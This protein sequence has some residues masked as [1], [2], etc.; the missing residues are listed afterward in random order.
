M[1]GLSLLQSLQCTTLNQ[2]SVKCCYNWES[3]FHQVLLWLRISLASGVSMT[4]NQ[5][6]IRCCHDSESAFHQVFPQLRI[7]LPSD[8]ATTENQTSIRCCHSWESTFCKVLPPLRNTS[9]PHERMLID[10]N[11][12]FYVCCGYTHSGGP[13]PIPGIGRKKKGSCPHYQTGQTFEFIYK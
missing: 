12:L 11:W 8:V 6:C 4:E 10:V 13:G 2:P 1:F 9:M 7:S 5:P 3:A